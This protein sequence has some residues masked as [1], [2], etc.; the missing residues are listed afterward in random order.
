MS[1]YAL[2]GWRRESGIGTEAAIKYLVLA[3]ASSAFL[4]FGM[5]LFYAD[6]GTMDL[7]RLAAGG[8]GR[9]SLPPS[10]WG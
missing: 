10:A 9:V 2:I 3:G 4:L 7:A 1:L 8:P 5:A 6:T